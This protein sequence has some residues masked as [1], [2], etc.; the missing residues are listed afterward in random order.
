MLEED[1][2]AK[3][4]LTLALQWVCAKWWLL[5]TLCELRHFGRFSWFHLVVTSTSIILRA[6]LRATHGA[7]PSVQRGM[8]LFCSNFGF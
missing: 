6:F 4:F 8:H 7:V 1:C 2:I 3:R 5:G